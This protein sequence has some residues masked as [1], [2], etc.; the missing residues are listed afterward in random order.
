MKSCS[1]L[2]EWK[3]SLKLKMIINSLEIIIFKKRENLTQYG[4]I[5]HVPTYR[6]SGGLGLR[7]AE[8]RDP[9]EQD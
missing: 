3:V 9:A 4:F 6:F 2:R 5:L 8:D 7:R 1:A